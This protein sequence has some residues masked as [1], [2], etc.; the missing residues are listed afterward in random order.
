[1]KGAT[2]GYIFSRGVPQGSVLMTVLLNILIEDLDAALEC[3]FSSFANGTKLGG[4][5]DSLET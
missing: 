1:M 3:I 2:Y 4:S 5:V